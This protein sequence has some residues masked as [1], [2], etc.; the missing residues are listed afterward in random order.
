MSKE[1]SVEVK[2]Q[3]QHVLNLLHQS[4]DKAMTSLYELGCFLPVLR[5]C[6]KEI[7]EIRD[8]EIAR[9]A[10]SNTPNLPGIEE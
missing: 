1:L 4:E 10:A 3:V 7:R 5:L 6:E 9:I 8:K 2:E